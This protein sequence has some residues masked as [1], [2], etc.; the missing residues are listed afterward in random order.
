[1]QHA[2]WLF[3]EFSKN[4]QSSE[5]LPT[6]NWVVLMAILPTDIRILFTHYDIIIYSLNLASCSQHCIS[7]K[8]RI[9]TS[10][11]ISKKIQF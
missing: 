5:K 8:Y 2:S 4:P 11:N 7:I 10:F 1:M 3:K 9:L 6:Y